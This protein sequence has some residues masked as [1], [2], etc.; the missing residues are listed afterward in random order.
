[1]VFIFYMPIPYP[2]TLKI[3]YYTTSQGIM[4]HVL[5]SPMTI[6]MHEYALDYLYGDLTLY[7]HHLSLPGFVKFVSTFSI[8]TFCLSEV[9][10]WIEYDNVVLHRLPIFRFHLP[11]KLLTITDKMHPAYTS[12]INSGRKVYL[13]S[14]HV[15]KTC[16]FRWFKWRICQSGI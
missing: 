15:N 13:K 8:T 7:S 6:W 10:L 14:S 9:C 3:K 16:T 11:T 5:Y 2:F 4:V 12:S 1:M